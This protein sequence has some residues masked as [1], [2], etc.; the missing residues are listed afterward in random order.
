[1]K[2][3]RLKYVKKNYK[4]N[5]VKIVKFYRNLHHKFIIVAIVKEDY[6]Y[7]FLLNN[8]M[9]YSKAIFEYFAKR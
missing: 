5:P 2:R 9:L 3:L 6:N 7:L 1:M 8:P 4:H